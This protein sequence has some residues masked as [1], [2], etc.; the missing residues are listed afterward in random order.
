MRILPVILLLACNKVEEPS[1]PCENSLPEGEVVVLA[2][3]FG[4]SE[5]LAFSPDGRLFITAG[6]IIAELQP[7]GSWTE[8]MPWEG[9][10]GLAW[11]EDRLIAAG[12]EGSVGVVGA[13]DV[14]T[15][16]AEILT[17]D[18]PTS[19]F[20]TVTPWNSILVSD[21]DAM[22]WEVGPTGT[23]T[24]W[25]ELPGP[26]GT[27]FTQQGDALW[28]VATWATPAP[29]W[30]IPLQGTTAGEPEVVHEWE[31]GN[32][33]DGVALG[34]S[35]DLYTSLN[36]TGKISRLGADGTEATV[37]RGVEFTASIAFG[38]HDRWDRC[39]VYSTSLFGDEVYQ[40][41]VGEPGQPVRF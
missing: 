8:L 5:G 16:T 26:N 6:E 21:A 3:G 15:R 38:N 40:V 37:A 41:G 2:E 14:D 29:A 35:G 13:I 36:V 34:E 33:P 30:R 24:P 17:R 25:L 12:R 10:V 39:S 31:G 23:T 28:A 20:I 22:I 18:I 11:W 1:D 7:D 19:N 27:A 32:F 4:P 9:G